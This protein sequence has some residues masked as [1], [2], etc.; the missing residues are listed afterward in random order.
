MTRPSRDSKVAAGQKRIVPEGPAIAGV[1]FSSGG[2][3]AH[4]PGAAD[5]NEA[6]LKTLLQKLEAHSEF[7]Q[8]DPGIRTEGRGHGH[9]VVQTG[10]VL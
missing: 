6:A 4:N 8:H 1:L 3:N 9:A 10:C 5:K 7:Y 2:T